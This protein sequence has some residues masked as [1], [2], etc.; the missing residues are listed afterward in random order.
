MAEYFKTLL[1]V[2]NLALKKLQLE[3][4]IFGYI[5]VFLILAISAVVA[6]I[7]IACLVRKL[8]TC[9]KKANFAEFGIEI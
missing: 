1:E 3:N 5:V 4:N 9:N 2:L 6:I 7:T 8:K